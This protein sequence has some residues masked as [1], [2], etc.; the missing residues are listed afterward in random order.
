MIPG[1]IEDSEGRLVPVDRANPARVLEDSVVRELCGMMVQLQTMAEVTKRTVAEQVAGL[2]GLLAEQYKERSE[3]RAGGVTL[4]SYDGRL[5]IERIFDD[6]FAVGPTMNAA[7]EIAREVIDEI[8]D[9]TAKALAARAF[10]RNR[11]T[12]ELSYSRLADLVEAEI[13]DPRWEQ[14]RQAIREAMRSVGKATYYRAYWREQSDQPWMQI[15]ADF[16]RAQEASS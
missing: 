7:E 15:S 6:R 5:K 13:D 4:Y 1:Y 2:V 3:G 11:R 12:G 9:P 14:A 16:S 10:R 8:T